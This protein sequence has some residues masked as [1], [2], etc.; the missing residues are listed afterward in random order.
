VTA[1]LRLAVHYLRQFAATLIADEAQRERD[2][3]HK[4]RLERE[5]AQLW[6]EVRS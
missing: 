6:S 3:K 4:V 2:P 5:A 1:D